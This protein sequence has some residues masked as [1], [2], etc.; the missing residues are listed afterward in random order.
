[1]YLSLVKLEHWLAD[2]AFFPYILALKTLLGKGS[3]QTLLCPVRRVE[4]TARLDTAQIPSLGVSQ[5]SFIAITNGTHY[6][7]V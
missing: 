1:M 7:T 4:G 2:V 3:S 5:G 6:L